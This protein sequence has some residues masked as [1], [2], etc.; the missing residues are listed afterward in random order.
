[1]DERYASYTP[2]N[3]KIN[4]LL[5]PG[6]IIPADIKKPAKMRKAKLNSRFF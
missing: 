4:V 6:I 5:T 2:S 3:I 1:M